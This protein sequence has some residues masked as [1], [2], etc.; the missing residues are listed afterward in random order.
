MVR[1]NA[2]SISLDQVLADLPAEFAFFGERYVSEI[3]PALAAR[4]GERQAAVIFRNRLRLGGAALALAGFA[5]FLF[6]PSPLVAVAGFAGGAGLWFWGERRLEP[7]RRETKRLLVE[8]VSR[9]FG[10]AFDPAPPRPDEIDLCEQMGLTPS[11]DRAAFED[12]LSGERG[13]APFVLFEA[14]LEER[15]TTV[16]SRGRTRTSWVTV[17]RGLCLKVRFSRPFSGVTRVFRDAGL[18]NAMVSFGRGGERVRLEDPVFEKTFEVYSTDQIEARFIL[19]P[20]FMER[21]LSLE[22]AFKGQS[23]RCAFTGGEM[24]LALE[25]RGLFEPGSMDRPLEDLERVQVILKDF[26]A[27]FLLIDAGLKR[28]G[29]PASRQAT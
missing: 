5:V 17:F 2:P 19:T 29:G 1:K 23:L 25:A 22:A 27:V 6:T 26:A 3:S 12:R 8:P 13:G 28:A 16:D 20:D 9:Q 21:L 14:H 4:E 10:M 15:R 24:L 11:F 18:F 7:L